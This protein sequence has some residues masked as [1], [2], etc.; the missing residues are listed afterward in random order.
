[1]SSLT[2]NLWK[3][4]KLENTI[5]TRMGKIYIVVIPWLLEIEKERKGKKTKQASHCNPGAMVKYRLACPCLKTPSSS[6][7]EALLC[8]LTLAI[9]KLY[10]SLTKWTSQNE[11]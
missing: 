11:V 8:V 10:C 3:F 6:Q 9:S 4:I 7:R 5:E 1:M 2:W